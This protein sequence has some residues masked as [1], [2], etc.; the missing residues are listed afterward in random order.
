[1]QTSAPFPRRGTR[2]LP[3]LLL[4]T[5]L[6]LGAVGL[7][8][9]AADAEREVVDRVVAMVDDEAIQLSEVLQEMNLARLQRNLGKLSADEQQ[10]L[11]RSVLE[12]MIN[13]QLLVAQAKAKGI[14]VSDEELREAVDQAI[15]DIKESMGGEEAYRAEL[16]RQ[17]LTEA[18]VRDL[19]REQKR[20]QILAQRL[21]QQEIR[22][23]VTITDEQLRNAWDTQ[24]D[25]LPAELFQTPETV[26]LAHILIAPRPDA[27]QAAA[28]RTKIEA[29]Q[30]RVAAGEDFATVAKQVSE[31]PTAANGGFLGAFRYGD[32]ESDAFDE[33]V[34]KLEPGG[35]TD[36]VETKFGLQ[37]IK[38]ESRKGDEMT[39]RHIVI[40]LSADENAQVRALDLAQ[41]IRSRALAGESFED[42]ARTYSD[43]TNTRDK[44]GVVDQELRTSEIV[45]DFRAALDSVA[46]G[47]V[48]NVV[49]SSAGFHLFKVLARTQPNAATFDGVRDTL[50]RYLEQREVE[51][52]YRT[53]LADLRKKFYVD[54]KV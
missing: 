2:R 12:D 1:M 29:A 21:I 36:I 33:A 11:F 42:M 16:A 34:S 30:K 19:H 47:S 26:R 38:L 8:P 44:G 7:A 25:S 41:S 50:R 49:R 31:W 39:A 53:Y 18:E 40:K 48:T 54:I 6:G 14:T 35:V 52:R 15:R 10:Q 9:P 23:T 32:F 20:K 5:G 4:V 13:D 17:G 27:V 3:A 37:I 28:A 51:R 24:R 45:P 22:R 46:V 43:D